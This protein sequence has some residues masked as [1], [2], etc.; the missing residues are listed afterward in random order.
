MKQGT[1]DHSIK[2]PWGDGRNAGR[3]LDTVGVKNQVKQGGLWEGETDRLVVLVG[4]V[5]GGWGRRW[6]LTP[7]LAGF[8]AP[9]LGPSPG[10]GPTPG[11]SVG[12]LFGDVSGGKIMQGEKRTDLVAYWGREGSDGEREKEGDGEFEAEHGGDWRT[13]GEG[14]RGGERV[15]IGYRKGK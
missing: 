15:F 8:S 4:A 13:G 7:I 5:I 1:H 11:L 9:G 12:R 10:L 6:T 14:T 2:Q 3:V